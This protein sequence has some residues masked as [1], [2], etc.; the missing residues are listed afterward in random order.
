MFT[1]NRALNTLPYVSRWP[2]LSPST[3]LLQLLLSHILSQHLFCAHCQLAVPGSVNTS[4]GQDLKRK[5]WGADEHHNTQ[6]KQL[7]RHFLEFAS[8]RH[9]PATPRSEC[10]RDRKTEDN[11]ENSRKRND[12]AWCAGD[13]C[14]CCAATGVN[15]V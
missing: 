9:G 13:C 4:R 15:A 1:S 3:R 10:G 8:K 7:S 6:Q 5:G 12:P 14:I 11:E 2:V